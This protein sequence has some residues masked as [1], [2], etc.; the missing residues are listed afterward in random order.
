MEQL[1]LGEK[2]G[3]LQEEMASTQGV[4]SL[5]EWGWDEVGELS[6]RKEQVHRPPVRRCHRL[7]DRHIPAPTLHS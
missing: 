5:A 4:L 7:L 2:A 1:W 6:K 3:R